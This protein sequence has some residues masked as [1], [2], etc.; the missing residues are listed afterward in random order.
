[1]VKGLGGSEDNCLQWRNLHRRRGGKYTVEVRY[2]SDV[3]CKAVLAV[4]GVAQ[5][6]ELKANSGYSEAAAE[7][8]LKKGDNFVEISSPDAPLPAVIDCIRISR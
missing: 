4:N 7:V 1:M 5:D 6:I 3:D 8:R 2:F